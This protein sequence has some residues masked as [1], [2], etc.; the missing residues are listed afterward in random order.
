V[1]GGPHMSAAPHF[2]GWMLSNPLSS[3]RPFM[4]T[5]KPPRRAA[6][7]TS[8]SGRKAREGSDGPLARFQL[9]ATSDPLES[10]ISE[11]RRKG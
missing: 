4:R 8:P 10:A 3:Q 6:G 7:V 1:R 11:A 2:Y 5:R 9:E